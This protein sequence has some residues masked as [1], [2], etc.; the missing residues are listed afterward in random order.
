MVSQSSRREQ[1]ENLLDA[2]RKIRPEK[3][4]DLLRQ[5]ANPHSNGQYALLRGASY[6]FL[7]VVRFVLESPRRNRISKENSILQARR[8]GFSYGAY[9][10][11]KNPDIKRAWLDYAWYL[12]SEKG[13]LGV[14]QLLEEHGAEPIDPQTK[15]LTD[16][17]GKGCLEDMTLLLKQ[18]VKP[19]ISTYL[20]LFYPEEKLLPMLQLLEEHGGDIHFNDDEILSRAVT[21]SHLE[22]VKY[23]VSK[24]AR[25]NRVTYANFVSGPR[26]GKILIWEYLLE[27][28]LN[29]KNGRFPNMPQELLTA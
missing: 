14:T 18:G 28:G 26:K 13:H 17:V 23:L 15:L 9:F 3:A 22:T 12:A 21:Q 25:V 4:L 11:S 24:G 29:V 1:D 27:N 16:A 6:G 19:H 20:A 8:Q 7:E 10:V 5:G 2:L